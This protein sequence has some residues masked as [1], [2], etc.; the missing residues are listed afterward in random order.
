MKKD[1]AASRKV[2]TDTTLVTAGRDPHD[3]FGFVNPPVFHGSTVLFPDTRTLLARDQKYTYARRGTPTSSALEAAVTELEGGYA[4]RIL[5][6]GL[7]AI[8]T[9]IM[10]IVKA[11]DHILM[12]DAVYLPGRKLCDTLL[13]QFGVETSYY[14]P[15]LGAGIADLMQPNTV[16]VYAESPGSMTMHMQDMPAI[17]EA[18]HAHGALVAFDN[19]WA[20]ALYFKPLSF[21]IDISIQAG[22]KYLGGHSDI[23]LGAVTVN[24]P[25]WDRLN[26]AY[27]RLGMCSGPDD[28]FLALRGLRTLSVRLERHYQSALE[29]ARWLGQRP[30]IKT[31][32]HPALPDHPGHD[33]W[34]RDFSGASGLFS[35]VFADAS[36]T[37]I[38]AFLDALT[39]F[40]MGASWGGYESLA[41][42]FNPS[43]QRSVTTWDEPVSGVRFHIGLEDVGDLK[44]DL[45]QAFSAMRAAG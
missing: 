33:I 42:P 9:A 21:G 12:T 38:M 17:V 39:L 36:E 13:K 20:T 16:L 28:H 45:D 37:Q 31:V 5:P 19:T 43:K 24:E 44:R 1:E 29:I 8:T 27:E 30:E 41:L 25:V 2:A 18:A 35:V 40:G 14:D 22:T 26:N 3:H 6:S 10:A 15:E 4:T 23:M 34:K 7:A 32:L 11:G